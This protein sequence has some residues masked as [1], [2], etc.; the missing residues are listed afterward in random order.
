MYFVIAQ[1]HLKLLPQNIFATL[2][3]YTYISGSCNQQA[4]SVSR[5]GT[6]VSVN[7]VLSLV[8]RA[9]NVPSGAGGI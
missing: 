4:V 3:T 1:H 2:G 7:N 9:C 6:V 8:K 5:H